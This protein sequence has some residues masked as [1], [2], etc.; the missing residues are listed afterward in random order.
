MKSIL[1]SA[2]G[3]LFGN[4]DGIVIRKGLI[5]VN[6]GSDELK[7][8]KGGRAMN[9]IFVVSTVVGMMLLACHSIL[10]VLGFAEESNFPDREIDV[11][12]DSK[13]RWM[14][15]E[16]CDQSERANGPTGIST[17]ES[18]QNGSGGGL[19][20]IRL[21][22]FGLAVTFFGLMGIAAAASHFTMSQTIGS[23]SLAAVVAYLIAVFL[24]RQ[25][26]L[27]LYEEATSQIEDV[28]VADDDQ[29]NSG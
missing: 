14:E 13:T 8:Q 27:S 5:D 19:A 20:L 2:N 15:D 10:Y 26:A 11:D 1:K 17:A 22:G 25:K 18:G 29:A 7:A 21:R 23:A 9:W 16:H 28:V 6:Q 24:L 12:R 4:F 3:L